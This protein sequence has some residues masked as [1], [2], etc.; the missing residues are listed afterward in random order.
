MARHALKVNLTYHLL[1]GKT[2]PLA[3]LADYVARVG[4]YRDLNAARVL[5][6]RGARGNAGDRVYPDRR[7]T[8]RVRA[9]AP[10]GCRAHGG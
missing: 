10:G 1:T 8:H 5:H 4:I 2:L 3:G 7:R 9:P 6:A